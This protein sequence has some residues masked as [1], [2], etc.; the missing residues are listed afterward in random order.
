MRASARAWQPA[1][2]AE[3]PATAAEQPA[4]TAAAK[5]LSPAASAFRPAFRAAAAHAATST[6]CC[7]R[8]H[9]GGRASAAAVLM[10]WLGFGT[11]K[12]GAS[13]ARHDI[14]VGTCGTLSPTHKA[15]TEEYMESMYQC[16]SP[17][18]LN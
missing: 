4:T 13:Q 2:A 16:A 6:A 7:A 18:S 11:Y 8:L 5:Q 14:N 9:G 1:T 15:F 10:P 17:L 3:Q 12:L